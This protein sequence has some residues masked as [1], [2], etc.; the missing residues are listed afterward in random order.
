M[1]FTIHPAQKRLYPLIAECFAEARTGD[2]YSP[3]YYDAGWLE[4]NIELFAALNGAGELVGAAGLTH[5]LFNDEKTTGCLLT[6]RPGF[7][8]YGI[9]KRLI[10]H[11]TGV[12]YRRGAGAV[13]GQVITLHT[14]VQKIVEDFGWIPTGF[15]P[16]ARHGK[17][18]LVLYTR[19][20]SKK[21]VGTLYIHSDI[22]GLA[23]RMYESLG[24]KADIQNSG[25]SGESG[26]NR[27]NDWHNRTV[28]VHAAECG[29]DLG[30]E[31]RE[32]AIVVLNLNDPSAVF[33]YEELRRAG[34]RFRGFD[35]AGQYEHAIFSN[36]DF[37]GDM[38]LTEQAETLK[39]EVEAV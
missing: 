30:N 38:Q 16:G 12:L 27:L 33:G 3:E 34:Y 28:Y 13:K 32:R 22:A 37:N 15:L 17:N 18:A 7:T 11:F 39:R 35:P 21:S 14:G 36:T 20:L 26:I 6:I 10:E 19:N 24:V 2:Y 29:V 4:S 23:K 31:L 25:C 1:S 5:G 9:A 8:G